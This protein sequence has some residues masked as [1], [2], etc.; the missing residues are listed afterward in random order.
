MENQTLALHCSAIGNPV[1]KITWSKDGKTVATGQTLSLEA[2]RN[3]S[4][5]YWCSAS[6]GIDAN[7]TSSV[8]LDVQCKFKY[9]KY[10]MNK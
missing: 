9:I 8:S 2:N 5:E 4:G 7:V 10:D 6:N 1:P 3:Q